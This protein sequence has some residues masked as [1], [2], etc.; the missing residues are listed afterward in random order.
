M[1]RRN[2]KPLAVG[3]LRTQRLLQSTATYRV[4]ELTD[5]D[6]ACVE[7]VRVP[8][9]APGKRVCLSRTSVARMDL[10]APTASASELDDELQ[11]TLVRWAA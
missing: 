9:L 5:A 1:G 7:V 11:R 10:L 8:G 2:Q 3:Q 4:V 6:H